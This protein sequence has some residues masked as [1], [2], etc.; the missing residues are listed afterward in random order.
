MNK[1]KETEITL[2]R[3]WTPIRRGPFYWSPSCGGRCSYE[4]YVSAIRAAEAALKRMNSDG[5]KIHVHENMGW[6]WE[7]QRGGGKLTLAG[8]QLPYGDDPSKGFNAMLS[9]LPG[10][11]DYNWHS[12]RRFDDPNQAVKHIITNARRHIRRVE[13]LLLEVS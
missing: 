2:I 11:G 13:K 3:N 8:G 5:W 12:T 7:L 9:N 10:A 4:Q 1:R 6:F